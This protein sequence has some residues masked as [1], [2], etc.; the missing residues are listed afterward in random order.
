MANTWNNLDATRRQ[1]WTDILTCEKCS[2]HER[3]WAREEGSGIRSLSSHLT[4][5]ISRLHLIG[6]GRRLSGKLC[7]SGSPRGAMRHTWAVINGSLPFSL[8][9]TGT[10]AQCTT[11]S[12]VW[13]EHCSTNRSTILHG[14]N[15]YTSPTSIKNGCNISEIVNIY[16]NRL[17]NCINISNII[18]IIR[19]IKWDGQGM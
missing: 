17:Y 14:Q 6:R 16:Q 7:G 15:L 12:Q 9:P 4:S 13:A 2:A 8:T 18:S 5:D 3:K 19:M 10:R 1:I 11:G